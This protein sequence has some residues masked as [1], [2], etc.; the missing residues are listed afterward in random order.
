MSVNKQVRRLSKSSIYDS[1]DSLLSST[2]KTNKRARSISI[3]STSTVFSNPPA[4]KI[5]VINLEREKK[6]KEADFKIF[7]DSMKNFICNGREDPETNAQ[8]TSVVDSLWELFLNSHDGMSDITQKK[9]AVKISSTRE[10]LLNLDAHA[11]KR[12]GKR[13]IRGIDEVVD[14]IFNLGTEYL[15]EGK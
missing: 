14:D 3:E 1:Q 4:K 7:S 12:I 2:I 8:W 15:F 6:Q 9:F 13:E 11:D 10:K 5:K